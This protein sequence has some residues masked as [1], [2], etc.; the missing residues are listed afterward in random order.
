MS[1]EDEGEEFLIFGQHFGN[2]DMLRCSDMKRMLST[3]PN[4]INTIFQ[5]LKTNR[6]SEVAF[7]A[8][9]GLFFGKFKRIDSQKFELNLSQ[10]EIY[11]AD[12]YVTRGT[13]YST[14]KMLACVNEDEC[15]Y[16]IDRT[17]KAPLI[18]VKWNSPADSYNYEV[19]RIP[20]FDSKKLP[21]IIL[22]DDFSIRLFN[23][24]TQKILS[25][26]EAPYSS[27]FGKIYKTM[28]IIITDTEFEA[29]Y[30]VSD[31]KDEQQVTHINRVIF[32]EAF[33]QT[34][35]SMVAI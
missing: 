4:K 3:N 12:K 19:F 32:T 7:C 20:G 18:K 17:K 24:N 26:K 16:L 22:R 6:K 15:F 30:L 34:L 21:F 11:L 23:V 10:T 5:I 35:R 8:Y 14:D 28:D 29:I 33:L 27:K 9:N 1:Y 13:E 31:E 25:I 2:I